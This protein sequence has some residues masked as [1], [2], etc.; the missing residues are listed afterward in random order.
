MQTRSTLAPY[1]TPA[2]LLLALVPQACDGNAV[3]RP[4]SAPPP[5]PHRGP[6]VLI[7]LDALR[8]D[9]VG[10]FGG[11]PFPGRRPA[12]SLTPHLDR[13]VAEADWSGRAVAPSSWTVPSMASLMTGL[14]PWQHGALHSGQAMLRED[15]DTLAEGLKGLGFRT[16]A[17]Y[18]NRWL[19]PRFGYRQGFEVFRHLGGGWRAQNRLRHLDG[20]PELVWVHILPPHT[21]Y[22]RN[23]GLA[24]RLGQDPEDL[25]ERVEPLDLEPYYDPAVELPPELREDFWTLYGHNVAWAD[26]RLG[27]LLDALRESGQWDRA[28]VAVTSDHGEEFGESVEQGGHRQTGHGGHLSRVLLEVPLVVK[29]PRGGLPGR[30]L[31][32]APGE[33]V[34]NLRLWA[35]LVEAAGGEVPPQVAPSLF[36]TPSRTAREAA[37]GILSELY[38]LNGVNRFSWIEGDRQLVWESSFAR[39]EPDYYR[40]R[41]QELG[42]APG[43]PPGF[44]PLT[45]PPAE[46]FAR[47]DR[48]FRRTPPLTGRRGGEGP[49]PRLRVLRWS[50]PD[51]NGEVIQPVDD[52]ALARRLARS[53]KTFWTERFGPEVPPVVRFGSAEGQ[54]TPELSP[55]DEEALRSLGYIAGGAAAGTQDESMEPSTE[56]SSEAR[57]GPVPR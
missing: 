33:R 16:A 26:H 18:T 28:L 49:V 12:V 54:A 40:A 11:E 31:A 56:R 45:E 43:R 24:R 42:A 30:R 8:A 41:L 46:L 13:L 5:P 19:H 9:F 4:P 27:E 47:L 2:L 1:L 38:R 23:D 51:A 55:E 34:A 48:A 57:S 36:E 52:P 53:L 29:L 14:Q 35:T 10:A 22:R 25:P 17:F 3:D 50:E 44:E 21:P 32:V 39:P 6:I 15:L 37:A 20:S 7:T